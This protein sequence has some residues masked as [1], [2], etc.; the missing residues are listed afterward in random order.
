MNIIKP[1]ENTEKGHCHILLPIFE[2]PFDLL[3][4][5]VHKEKLDIHAIPLGEITQQYLG[6][7]QSMQKMQVELAG[8]FLVMAASLLCLKS[9][10]LLP[11]PPR[12]LAGEEEDTFFFGSK[13]ELVQSLL[14]YKRFKQAAAVLGERKNRQERIYLR[15]ADQNSCP[16][17]KKYPPVCTAD[18][19]KLKKAWLGLKLKQKNKPAVNKTI[20]IISAPKT[21]FITILRW[22]VTSIRQNTFFNSFLDDFGRERTK[23]EL[24]SIFTL[25]LELARRGR[26]SLQQEKAFSRIRIL[27]P[28]RKRR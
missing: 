8:E 22:V 4:Y 7:L 12:S 11:Q 3:F 10:L 18:P 20:A 23:E 26:L 13:E 19:E 21:H 14:N 17:E 15:P 27:K 2:G 16:L 6:Y 9:R 25:F 5:L 1:E 28:F 24:V